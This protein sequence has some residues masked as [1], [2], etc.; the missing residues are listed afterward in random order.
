MNL[1]H[2]GCYPEPHQRTVERWWH[3]DVR[4]LQYGVE[5]AQQTVDR[6]RD[7]RRAQR[8]GGYSDE[9]KAHDAFDRVLTEGG[10]RVD[11]RVDVMHD[12]HAPQER[13]LMQESVRQVRGA[14]EC[15]QRD[16]EGRNGS[17]AQQLEQSEAALADV[18]SAQR[19]GEIEQCAQGESDG[20]QPEVG[21]KPPVRPPRLSPQRH[22][23][24]DEACDCQCSQDRQQSEEDRLNFH[25][26]TLRLSP[27]SGSSA[28]T[29][30]YTRA[31]SLEPTS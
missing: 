11:G 7:R 16:D 6:D 29:R 25:A 5:C 8:Q 28:R 15:D 31:S 10:S 20:Q 18:S 4:V 21:R 27:R 3:A 14:V 13:H 23:N 24:F 19:Q 2:V 17:E 9:T 30:V 26:A 12:V 1:V 22:E